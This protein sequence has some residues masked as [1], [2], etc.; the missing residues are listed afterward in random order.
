MRASRT[1]GLFM[2]AGMSGFADDRGG[3]RVVVYVEGHQSARGAAIR[4]GRIANEMFAAA[5]V[6]VDWKI[7]TP[8]PAG[9]EGGPIVIRFTTGESFPSAPAALAYALPYA[10]G[11]TSV[12][13]FWDRVQRIAG[14]S[15]F[16]ETLL[17]HVLAHEVTHILQ[18]VVR[19]SDG[20][21]MRANWTSRDYFQMRDAPLSFTSGD[22]I[23]IR[24]GLEKRSHGSGWALR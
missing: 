20:G 13:V 21:I 24:M 3:G 2:L 11:G 23:L 4:A 14:K 22:V 12:T 9:D 16:L 6:E 5:G 8:S 15:R 17:A 19:H 18:G 10:N 1:I 7:G